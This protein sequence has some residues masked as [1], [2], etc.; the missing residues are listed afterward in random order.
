MNI[1][2]GDLVVT[3]RGRYGKVIQIEQNDVDNRILVRIG[4]N[5]H[6]IAESQ[7]T[8]SENCIRIKVVYTFKYLSNTISD[9]KELSIK[10]STIL[11]D[12]NKNITF[13]DVIKHILIKHLTAINPE[14]IT[15]NQI[16]IS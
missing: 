16:L 8:K 15:I 10:K 6:W 7:L 13:N 14:D 12:I 11:Y 4:S 2:Q 5:T 1:V 9:S 3:S